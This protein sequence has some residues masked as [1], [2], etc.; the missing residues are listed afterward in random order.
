MLLSCIQLFV[1][2][3]TALQQASLS[4]ELSRQKYW[5]GLPFTHPG[6]LPNPGVEPVP[7]CFLLW[8]AILYHCTTW[9]AHS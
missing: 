8:Q 3:W 7:L 2:L 4:M 1:I 5:G 6:D 9:E